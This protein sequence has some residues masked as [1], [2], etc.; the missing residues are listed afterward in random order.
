MQSLNLY[1]NGLGTAVG[2]AFAEMLEKN[3]SLQTLGLGWNA[4]GAAS[5]V[6]IAKALES[7]TAL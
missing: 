6:A 7:N 4:L 5:V 3:F 2:V 1:N